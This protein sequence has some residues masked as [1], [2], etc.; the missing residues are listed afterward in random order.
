MD[1]TM[2]DIHPVPPLRDAATII[3]VR[4]RHARPEIYLLRRNTNAKF[5]GGLY[6]FPGD[7]VDP[8]DRGARE[9]AP[10]IDMDTDQIEPWDPEFK[11]VH[12]I[13]T[14][15]VS[16]KILAP[17]SLFSRLWCDKGVWKPVE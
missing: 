17:G 9:W 10:Y 13:D 12:K 15:D 2:T 5:M 1:K 7:V 11:T 6:V 8:E 4:E 14:A 3:L 16:K